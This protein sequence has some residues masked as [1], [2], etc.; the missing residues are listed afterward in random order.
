M[1]SLNARSSGNVGRVVYFLRGCKGGRCGRI[2][3]LTYADDVTLISNTP[4]SLTHMITVL[5]A[6]LHNEGGHDICRLPMGYTKDMGRT[7]L[8]KSMANR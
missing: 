2:T 6:E 8:S 3:H 5:G 1:R 7:K 4:N